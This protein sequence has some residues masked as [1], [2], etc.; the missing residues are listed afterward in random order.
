MTSEKV[1]HDPLHGSIAVDGV[2]LKL[3]SRHEVQRLHSVKQLGMANTVFPGANHTRLEHSLGVYHLAGR[4]CRALGLGDED[5]MHVRAAAL[6]HDICHLPYSHNISE[7]YENM[8]GTDHMELAR[9]L[10]KGTIPTYPE[11]DEDLLGGTDTIAEV[12]EANGMSSDTVCDLIARPRSS[13]D[14]LGAFMA[15]D[16]KQSFFSS[17]DHLHQMIHGPVDAD[18]MDYLLRDAHYT[19]VAHGSIDI[20]RLLTQMKVFN[21]TIVIERGGVV[22]AEGL[23]VSR[24]L[25]YTSVYFNKTVR[26]AE[27][28]LSKAVELSDIDLR[29]IH[30]M[31]DPELRNELI[32][33]GGRPSEM[34][35]SL[36]HRRLYKKAFSAYSI[37]LD[38][39]QIGSIVRY[40][41]YENKKRLEDEIAEAAGVDYSEVIVDIPSRSSLLSN[42][43]IGKT[44][45]SIYYDGRVRPITRISPV[46]KALQSR[47]TFDW[48]IMISSPAE[49]RER[50]GKAASS[51]LSL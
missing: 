8:T 44:D 30:L 48:A 14:G 24:A 1:I 46:S 39:D 11:R 31:D 49:H 10:I 23:M 33:Q 19:G 36:I 28:M 29:T 15:G 5:M 2:F 50:V 22:A 41:K 18:Q 34:M 42:A 21:N 51:I 9:P 45:V 12:L 35:R 37:D 26:I 6:L 3:L 25:M 4:M 17:K 32:R 7:L 13:A 20:E 47:D 40:S 38:E 16:G 43:K 27:M